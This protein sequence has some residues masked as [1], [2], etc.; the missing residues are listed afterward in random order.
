MQ[1]IQSSVT[2]TT[3]QQELIDVLQSSDCIVF[4]DTNLLAWAFRLNETASLE[5]QQWL[6]TLAL[7]GS[8]VGWVER[9][10]THRMTLKQ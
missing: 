8:T 6:D 10:E 2:L 7:L 9:S 4:L 3:Y 1:A 5:L